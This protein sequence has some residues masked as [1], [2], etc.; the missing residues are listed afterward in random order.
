MTDRGKTTW[1]VGDSAVLD[2]SIVKIEEIRGDS[3]SATDGFISMSG[4]FMDRLRPVTPRNKRTV[5]W[6]EGCYKELELI[7]GEGGF[8]YPDISRHFSDLSLE[9]ID[10][11]EDNKAPFDRATDFIRQ[12]RLYTPVIQGVPLFRPARRRAQ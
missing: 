4:R 5:E 6:F 7:N 11:P 2:L 12:A 9:A 3:C 1:K 10:G 8:N